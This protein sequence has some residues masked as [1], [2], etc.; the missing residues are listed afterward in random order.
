[1]SHKHNGS[2]FDVS[3]L[4]PREMIAK[5]R[6]YSRTPKP[7]IRQMPLAARMAHLKEH[8]HQQKAKGEFS[9]RWAVMDCCFRYGLNDAQAARVLE[10]SEDDVHFECGIIKQ[11]AE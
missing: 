1:M 3:D 9:L 11:N 7:P 8:Y 2:G 6:N 4:I 10:C 5:P